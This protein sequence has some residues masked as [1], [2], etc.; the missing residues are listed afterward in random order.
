VSDEREDNEADPLTTLKG[1][2]GG[3]M[4]ASDVLQ[5]VTGL[6]KSCGADGSGGG[7]SGSWG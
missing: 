2:S 6:P 3:G 7:V 4:E 1:D 5:T